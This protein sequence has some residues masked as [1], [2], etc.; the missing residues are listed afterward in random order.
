MHYLLL[1]GSLRL[2]VTLTCP[3]Q[4][5]TTPS[6]LRRCSCTAPSCSGRRVSVSVARSRWIGVF[7]G[8]REGPGAHASQGCCGQRC[9]G[10][11]AKESGQRGRRLKVEGEEG[12]WREGKASSPQHLP[13]RGRKRCVRRAARDS[14]LYSNV[15]RC[16][17]RGRMG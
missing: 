2:T 17:E 6:R 7:L 10:R 14:C 1:S 5:G 3:L 12:S 13:Q 8:Q 9:F 4:G 15:G 16:K 11:E